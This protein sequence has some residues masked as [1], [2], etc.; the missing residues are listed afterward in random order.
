[1]YVGLKMLKR[2]Q[3]P[4][5]TPDSLVIDAE[6]LMEQHR[7]WMILVIEGD[8]LV[9]YVNREDT[10]EA[11]PSRATSL[12]R[13]EINYLLTKL[14]VKEIMR[15]DLTTVP[16]HMEI[17]E[18]ADIMD[19][20]NLAGVAVV[21]RKQHLLG[22]INRT[23]ML[24]V[25][26]EEMGLRLG[27]SRIAFEVEDRSGVIHEVSGIIARLGMSII[28]TSTFFHDTRRLVVFRIKTA[29]PS[30]VVKELESLGYRMV[31]PETFEADWR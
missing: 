31:G 22:Y 9:G 12:S 20:D 5:V 17:E 6:K 27:G 7:L 25:L 11:L 1:M 3:F 21:D 8:R 15:K 18:C 4:T 23:V 26:V 10:A 19:R 24:E 28:S 13:H 30:P 29:D 16:P 2:S 14:K